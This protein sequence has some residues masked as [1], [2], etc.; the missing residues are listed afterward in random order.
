[1]KALIAMGASV[2]VSMNGI[3]VLQL[4]IEKCGITEAS[5]T[6]VDLV[7]SRGF[8]KTISPM[9]PID[10]PFLNGVV[11]EEP[12]PDN[13]VTL[14]RSVGATH[15]SEKVFTPKSTNESGSDAGA[16]NFQPDHNKISQKYKELNDVVKTKR[17]KYQRTESSVVACEALD[18]LQQVD[19]YR[20]SNGCKILCLDG[21]GVRGLVQIEMLRQIE[22]KTGKKIIDLFD[23]IVGT[24]TG[25]I[26][27]LALVY[28]MYIPT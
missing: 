6:S 14:L 11:K 12:F 17:N 27:A 9:E 15:C 10:F 8:E 21:G 2:N 1:M 20:M 5:T 16:T 3:T 28:G 7:D 19:V 4:A 24:S 26:I 25:G 22:Q 13:M 18:A 23:W